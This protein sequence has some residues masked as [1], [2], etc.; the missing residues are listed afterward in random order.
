MHLTY[1]TEIQQEINSF[2]IYY[3][4]PSGH[5][6][7][8][9]H[10]AKNHQDKKCMWPILLR[11]IRT[12]NALDLYDLL[13]YIQMNFIEI[14][15][16]FLFQNVRKKWNT[17]YGWHKENWLDENIKYDSKYEEIKY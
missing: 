12:W 3:W 13:K 10:I 9:T 1:I 7:D 2:D 15:Y 4:E 17:K 8:L 16:I 6:A 5:Q 11:I 14:V